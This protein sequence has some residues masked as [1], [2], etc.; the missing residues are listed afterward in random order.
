MQ[1]PYSP[2]EIPTENTLKPT[3]V[4]KVKHLV[5]IY[6]IML[7]IFFTV[8]KAE[9]NENGRVIIPESVPSHLEKY[10][11]SCRVVFFFHKTR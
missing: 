9:H 3:I 5:E 11:G 2:L 10:C 4:M 6:D 7:Y 8:L 1:W